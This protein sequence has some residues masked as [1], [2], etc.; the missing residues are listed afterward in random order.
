MVL[1]AIGAPA[2]V[3]SIIPGNETRSIWLFAMSMI[4][5]FAYLIINAKHVVKAV[6]AWFEDD[7]VT[8][9]DDLPPDSEE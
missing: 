4:C 3:G 1:T 2:A 9:G 5:S 6:K 7:D 8:T